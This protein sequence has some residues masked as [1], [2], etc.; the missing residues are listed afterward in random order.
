MRCLCATRLMMDGFSIKPKMILGCILVSLSNL[1]NKLS[2][3]GI[4][5]DLVTESILLFSCGLISQAIKNSEI[6]PYI[7]M[8]YILRLQLIKQFVKI[9]GLVQTCQI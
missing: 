3:S 8:T 6:N 2:S 7:T 1:N 5:K 4:H 9:S